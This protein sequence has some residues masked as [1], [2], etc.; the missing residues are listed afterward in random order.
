MHLCII[1][2]QLQYK[3]SEIYL[4]SLQPESNIFFTIIS[5]TRVICGVQL[6]RLHHCV[7][8][9]YGIL[10]QYSTLMHTCIYPGE[11]FVAHKNVFQLTNLFI[12]TY[13]VSLCNADQQSGNLFGLLVEDVDVLPSTNQA[14]HKLNLLSMQ[15]NPRNMQILYFQL[16]CLH[17]ANRQS[18]LFR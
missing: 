10:R 13:S 8:E 1:T 6:H 5:A 15:N 2:N 16:H 9:V 11:Y 12:D 3:K 18:S 4:H 14:L 17:F 7:L